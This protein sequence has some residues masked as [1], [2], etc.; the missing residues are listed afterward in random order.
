[1]APCLQLTSPPNLCLREMMHL[2]MVK[3]GCVGCSILMI[4]GILTGTSLRVILSSTH[5]VFAENPVH[6]LGYSLLSA[7]N[8]KTK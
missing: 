5:T 4:Q 6:S 2:F 3:P 8:K 1:M 7:R